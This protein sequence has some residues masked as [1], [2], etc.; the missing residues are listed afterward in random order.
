MLQ[1]DTQPALIDQVHDKLLGA[2]ADGT[3]PAGQKLTQESVA[4]M[5]GV[6]RQPVSHALQVLK[7]VLKEA[8]VVAH[9]LGRRV[10]FVG[11]AGGQPPDRLQFLGLSQ[12]RFKNPAL[13]Y[14]GSDKEKP[15]RCDLVCHQWADDQFEKPTSAVEAFEVHLVY[16]S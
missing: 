14:V 2:I 1:L 6:S 3:L 13:G 9:E 4:T 15:R 10:D 7:G 12:L 5:L 16:A 8:R 11:D